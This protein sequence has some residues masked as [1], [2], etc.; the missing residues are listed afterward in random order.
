MSD[1]AI[2]YSIDAITAATQNRSSE[3]IVADYVMQRTLERAIEIISE[4]AKSLSSE[5]RQRKPDVPWSDIISIGNM[6]RH[7]YYRIR[8]DVMLNILNTHLP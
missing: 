5:I 1:F 4:A 2:S 7:E 8:E 3:E 6:L